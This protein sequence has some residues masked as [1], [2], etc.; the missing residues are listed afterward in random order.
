MSTGKHGSSRAVSQISSCQQS[1][2]VAEF[3][4]TACWKA[5]SYHAHAVLQ[6]SRASWNMDMYPSGGVL[7]RGGSVPPRQHMLRRLAPTPW[8]C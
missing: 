8:G 3:R 1:H 7:G 6:T 4:A 2:R 5:W